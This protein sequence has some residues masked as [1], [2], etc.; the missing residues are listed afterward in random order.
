MPA[1][2]K[3]LMCCCEVASALL[4]AS[5]RASTMRSSSISLSSVI[6]LSSMLTRFTLLLQVMSTF[7][8]PEPAAPSTSTL[9]S[10]ACAFFMFSCICW[11]CFIRLPMPPFII[12]LSCLLNG[13]NAGRD[14]LRAEILNQSLHKVI[15]L[16]RRHCLGLQR[17]FFFADLLGGRVASATHFKMQLNIFIEVLLDSGTQFFLVAL[18]Q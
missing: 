1:G 4:I 17:G 9:A 8:M 6:R 18:F 7:T 10:S 12:L 14:N 15:F 11:A 3:L 2:M 16:D 5:F 13:F